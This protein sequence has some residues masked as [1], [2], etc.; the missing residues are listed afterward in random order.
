M[1]YPRPSPDDLV[2]RALSDVEARMPGA[3]ARLPGAPERELA[4][5][6]AGF[7]HTEHGHIDHATRQLFPHLCEDRFVEEYMRIFKVPD[8]E[9]GYGKIRAQHAKGITQMTGTTGTINAGD[10]FV[11]GGRF[12]TADDSISWTGILNTFDIDIT[13]EDAGAAGNVDPGTEISLVV[14]TAG[15][16]TEGVTGPAG[17]TGGTDIESNDAAR[18]RLVE[19]IG[20]PGSGG[21]S[22]DFQVWARAA[23]PLVTRVWELPRQ[24][25]P[26]T[27][28]VLIANDNESPPVPDAALVQ[29]VQDHLQKVET[30]TG[31]WLKITG[32]APVTAITTV[33][34]VSTKALDV[35]AQVELDDGEIWDDGEGGGVKPL[36][37]IEIAALIALRAEPGATIEL[38]EIHG[39][40]QRAAG[41]K[42]HNLSAPVAD[43]TH[44]TTEIPIAGTHTLTE[45]V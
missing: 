6:A 29:T 11:V 24:L 3:D 23:S 14:P 8:G 1:P 20:T 45:T 32:E 9:G 30:A 12:Y 39:A 38:E 26:G 13:A 27:V 2:R 28:Q 4:K 42:S 35:T 22:G 19:K 17:I 25:G 18:K 40:I 31:G 21:A 10:R 16:T 43:V 7:A 5:V 34:A 37:E 41:V 36:V 44:T 33:T 15:V